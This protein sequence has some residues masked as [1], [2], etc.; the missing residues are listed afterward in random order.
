VRLRLTSRLLAVLAMVGLITGP[1]AQQT[2]WA[3][4][5]QNFA[6]IADSSSADMPDGMSC[7]PETQKKPDC[8][9]DCPFM[10]VCGGM[11]GQAT[12]GT[13]LIEPISLLGVILPPD[14]SRLRGLAQ[15]PPAKP[16]KA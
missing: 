12:N 9:K 10:A 7:C 16:P 1:F 11:I 4:P 14:D 6:E 5:N 15:G 13:T 8:A 3:A 2:T